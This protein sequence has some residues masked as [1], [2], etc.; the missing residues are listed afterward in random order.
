MFSSFHTKNL[1]S[2]R[3]VRCLVLMHF[4]SFNHVLISEEETRESLQSRLTCFT[5]PSSYQRQCT[6]KFIHNKFVE[7]LVSLYFPSKYY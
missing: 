6:S 1:I 7:C 3:D 2:L 4:S 5:S